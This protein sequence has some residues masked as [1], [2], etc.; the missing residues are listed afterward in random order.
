MK[1]RRFDFTP[2]RCEQLCNSNEEWNSVLLWARVLT[3]AVFSTYAARKTSVLEIF[4]QLSCT[5]D[6][7]NCNVNALVRL[8]I[9]VIRF[10]G[11]R[12]DLEP[13][14]MRGH[15]RST[16]E[17]QGSRRG[18]RFCLGGGEPAVQQHHRKP[19]HAVY[20]FAGAAV[21]AG[22]TVLCQSP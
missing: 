17:P 9:I 14:R 22:D 15:L 7:L 21:F 3:W 1:L 12:P 2:V 10:L 20:K 11:A 19:C 18:S 5:S 4:K 8:P 6:S 16:L 13:A